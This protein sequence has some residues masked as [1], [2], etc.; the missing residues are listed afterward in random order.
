MSDIQELTAFVQ[1]LVATM[2]LQ[3]TD[4]QKVNTALHM[5]NENQTA[6]TADSADTDA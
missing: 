1:Q 4:M 6:D 2:A 3:A 5:L